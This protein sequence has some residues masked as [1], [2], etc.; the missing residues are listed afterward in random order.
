MTI[1]LTTSFLSPVDQEYYSR[2]KT[3]NRGVITSI[4]GKGWMEYDETNAQF[5]W[6]IGAFT[7]SLEKMNNVW[8]YGRNGTVIFSDHAPSYP[9]FKLRVPLSK[10][11]EF[12]YF[13]A[14]LNSDVVDSSSS[15]YVVYPDQNYSKFREVDH[16]KFIAAHQLEISL[17]HGVDFSIGESVVYSDQRSIVDIFNS[18]YVLQIRRTL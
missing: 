5:S 15:Y 7:F 12:V 3:N 13:H 10:D 18:C 4:F 14:E 16:S 2:I 1:L 17:W 11:I 9:Q 8:G 6:Q